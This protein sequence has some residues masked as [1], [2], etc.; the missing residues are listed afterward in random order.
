M[1]TVYFL[2]HGFSD[3][4]L[5]RSGSIWRN[6]RWSIFGKRLCWFSEQMGGNFMSEQKTSVMLSRM[7][8]R[9]EK[10][11]MAAKIA[12]WWCSDYMGMVESPL[13][14]TGEQMCRWRRALKAIEGSDMFCSFD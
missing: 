8:W 11:I 7:G 9:V 2:V 5:A 14:Y 4:P 1:P 12:R 13:Q 10:A 3:K 6:A